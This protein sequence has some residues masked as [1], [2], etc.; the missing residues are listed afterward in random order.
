MTFTLTDRK[1]LEDVL[2]LHKIISENNP[3][4]FLKQRT[5]GV[6]WDEYK[7]QF[8]EWAESVKT[9][10]DYLDLMWHI[11]KTAKCGHI[12]PCPDWLT[13]LHK[14]EMFS[15]LSPWR[16]LADDKE[17]YESN[18]Y[19]NDVSEN[20]RKH[21]VENKDDTIKPSYRHVVHDVELNNDT[22]YMSLP[23]MRYP[24]EEI[25]AHYSK[26]V[27]SLEQYKNFII[28]VRG[29]PGGGDGAW[30]E[31]LSMIICKDIT[32]PLIYF[33]RAG[34]HVKPFFKYYFPDES[35]EDIRNSSLYTGK[36]D[37]SLLTNEFAKPY[38]YHDTV[39][40]SKDSISFSG[41]IAVIMNK[42]NFSSSEAFL[43]RVKH[44]GLA[45]MIGE[46]SGGDGIGCTPA[47][48]VL[49]NSRLAVRYPVILGLNPNSTINDEYPT[50][51]DVYCAVKQF[52]KPL[53]MYDDNGKAWLLADN[54]VQ[55]A[56]NEFDRFT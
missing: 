5:H 32:T 39:T 44:S 10:E 11:C 20:K 38:I 33:Y 6:F 12:T 36:F 9:P 19:W 7:D 43:V 27:N 34:E 30:T 54:A 17:N 40:R 55:T 56:M 21:N 2:F 13:S 51:P 35:V 49:P 47:I 26:I 48:F 8:C 16:I 37:E 3:F 31:F 53:S 1:V 29:N 25:M 15:E 50:S 45:T 14:L 52:D 24:D 18:I 28:D 4:K 46:T 42:I 22:L 23:M 41:K